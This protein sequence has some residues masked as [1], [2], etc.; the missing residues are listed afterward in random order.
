MR[1]N[2]LPE[3]RLKH[4]WPC[5][6]PP[7]ECIALLLQ[8]GGALGAYQ[9][10]VYEGL[11]EAGL[12][13]DWTAGISIGAINA[14]LIAGNPPE[15]RVEKLREFWELVTSPYPQ[16]RF[17][18]MPA[19]RLASSEENGAV[20][21]SLSQLELAGR[22]NYLTSLLEGAAA[23]ILLNQWSAGRALSLGAPGFFAPRPLT[24]W[25]WPHGTIEATSY[26]DTRPL[27]ATLE[28]LVDF[29][30][31]NSGAMRFSVGAVNVRTGNFV[32]FDSTTHRIG[33]EHV[34]ASGALPPGFPAIEIDG[35]HYWDGGI[36]SNTP[37]RWVVEN[38]PHRDT[39]AFQVD[40]WSSRGEAPR[41]IAQVPTRQKEIQYSSRTRAESERFREI[42]VLRYALSRLIDKLPEELAASPEVATLR[43][44]TQPKAWNLI[45]LIYR[46]N[47]Y[48]GEAK[49]Y[50]F[51][52][53][54]M[55]E[56][57]RAGYHDTVRTLR[58]PEVL[59]RPSS[60]DGTFMFDVAE[61]GRE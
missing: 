54:S 12:H 26:Y 44:A 47:E 51:S 37:L 53:R 50:E 23:R 27:R 42:Q 46:S 7:F 34:M 29:D 19:G 18:L 38:E 61:H 33:P 28:R 41:N 36:I 49:D 35:E 13:P 1:A 22:D 9:G 14:A 10:G 4:H 55:E 15:E 31:I 48:E 3:N 24:P 17:P 8:G 21:T 57:W 43:R 6:R 20:A 52:R 56:R 45:Q 25:L 32:Y 59:E 40:L 30:R 11:A 16:W 5:G 2:V 39:L 58:H 60:L